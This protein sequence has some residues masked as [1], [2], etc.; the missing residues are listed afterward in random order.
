[1]NYP[2]RFNLN[3]DNQSNNQN[4]RNIRYPNFYNYYYNSSF[5]Q[6]YPYNYNNIFQSYNYYNINQNN[7]NNINIPSVTE[8]NIYKLLFWNL[9]CNEYSYDWKTSPKIELKYKVWEYRSKLFA[10]L[11]SNKSIIS[12]LYCFVEVDKQDDIYLMLNTIVNQKLYET[13]YYPRP[14]TPL[15]I[16]LL[17][18]RIK[19]KLIKS[20][21]YYLGTNINQNF[22]LVAIL[23]ENY[24]PNNFFA[25]I[26]TH[27]IAR[28]KN[29]KTRIKQINKFFYN[30]SNDNLLKN[31][32]I[33]KIIICGDLNTNPDSDCIKQILGNNFKSVFD[34][35]NKDDNNYTIVIDT[36]DE[37]LKKLKFDYIFISN[38]I[39]IK[40]KILPTNFLDFEKGLPNE[41]FP[42]DHIYLFTEFQFCKKNDEII[43]DFDKII[44]DKNLNYELSMTNNNQNINN[45]KNNETN[46]NKNNKEE[47]EEKVQDVKGKDDINVK[48]NS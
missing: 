8:N 23:Q 26:I 18:N 40:N 5:N 22:A 29:E 2:N 9:L 28:D 16:M 39:N 37:G 15:G 17:Y 43:Y 45:N 7:K 32:K 38:N 34:I 21:K 20:Y 33:N 24:F 48:N 36:I 27:L 13:V 25:I 12:D 42:S 19:F 10:Q 4:N 11:F 6:N 30:L 35:N 14:S 31:L 44:Y 47:N 3:N 46:K 1:M 41:N